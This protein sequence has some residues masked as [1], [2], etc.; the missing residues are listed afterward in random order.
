MKSVVYIVIFGRKNVSL[1]LRNCKYNYYAQKY[2]KTTERVE[3]Q[4]RT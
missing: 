4:D 3:K 2:Y 1:R